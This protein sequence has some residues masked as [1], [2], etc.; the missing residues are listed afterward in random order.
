M[1]DLIS[2][3]DTDDKVLRLF[4][5]VENLKRT[6]EE[7]RNQ[8]ALE[9]FEL[10]E[11]LESSETEAQLEIVEEKLKICESELEAAV[12]R[13]ERAE[14]ECEDLKKPPIP[15]P[16]P[17]PPSALFDSSLNLTP[18]RLKTVLSLNNM[19]KKRENAVEDMEKLLGLDQC[20]KKPFASPAGK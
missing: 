6:L 11:K 5:E 10:Q 17:P 16:P 12:K 8:H 1:G 14:T 19:D 20:V 13:A 3:V 18:V 9:L 2:A 15:P 4:E 7:E